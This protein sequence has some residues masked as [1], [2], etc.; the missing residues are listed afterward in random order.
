MGIYLDLW[1]PIPLDFLV[2]WNEKVSITIT[3]TERPSGRE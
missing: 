3:L 2:L 1:C